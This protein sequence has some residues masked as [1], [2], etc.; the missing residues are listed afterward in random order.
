MHSKTRDLLTRGWQVGGQP[1][2]VLVPSHLS[3]VCA[4]FFGIEKHNLALYA[5]VAFTVISFVGAAITWGATE[6]CSS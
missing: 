6:D 5:D 2:T 3:G 1:L 4:P